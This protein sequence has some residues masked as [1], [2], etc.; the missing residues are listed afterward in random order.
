MAE[1]RLRHHLC[2]D[3]RSSCSRREPIRLTLSPWVSWSAPSSPPFSRRSSNL[4]CCRGW[5]PS[6]AF[7][8][9]IGLYLVPV[10][11]LVAQ[12][13]QTAMFTA[14]AFNFVPLLAPANQMSYDTVQFYNTALAIVAGIGAGGA[15]VSPAA[16]AVA[17]AADA[18]APGPDLARS[19]PPRNGCDPADA[20]RLG[21]PHVRPALGIAGSRPSRCSARSS[22]R[23]SRW[24]P[25]SSGFAASRPGSVWAR[26][27][28]RRSRPWREA[29]ARSRPHGLPGSTTA[30]PLVPARSRR[31]PLALRARASI[32]A[33]SEALTEHASYFDAGAPG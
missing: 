4:R 26:T 33:I 9:A 18:P 20:R 11:A 29:T 24:A 17:G 3:R 13:W 32:L 30:S 10:G 19:A 31:R 25:R 12:P 14:M 22:W 21:G 28:T 16:A 5:R 27:S 1:W 23:R 2:R 6:Q 8:I 7:S 15:F